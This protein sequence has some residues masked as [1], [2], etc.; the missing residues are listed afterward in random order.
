MPANNRPY[1]R[2]GTLTV[3]TLVLVLCAYWTLSNWMPKPPSKPDATWTRIVLNG[4]F[5]IGV[6]PSFPPF[7]I[8]DGKGNLSGFDIALADAIVADWSQST[9]VSIRTQYVYTGF[10]GLYD[11]L[12]SDQFDAILSALPYDP[13]KTQDVRYSHS[14]FNGGPEVVV[15]VAD[16]T[17]KSWMDLAGRRVGVELGSTGDTFARRWERRLKY[18]LRQYNTPTDALH[19]LRVGQVDGVFTDVIALDGFL[20]TEGEVRAVGKPVTDELFVIAVSKD[21]PTLL[22]QINTVIDAMKNDGRLDLVQKEWF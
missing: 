19:G 10:D 4:A 22:Y 8:D 1:V 13:K 3:V 16:S 14:Y 2:P 20:K 7:E 12:K 15:R 17:V 21:A 9:G 6:D 5:R 11:A 18:T